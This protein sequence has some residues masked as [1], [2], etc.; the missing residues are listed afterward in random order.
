MDLVDLNIRAAIATSLSVIA[1]VL[2]YVVFYK[3][4]PKISKV[5]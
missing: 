1:F 5:R 2:V 4:L 3:N